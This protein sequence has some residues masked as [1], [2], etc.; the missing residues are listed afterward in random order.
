MI[1]LLTVVSLVLLI[2]GILTLWDLHQYIECERIINEI[3]RQ[4]EMEKNA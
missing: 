1:I 2:S 3:R 4:Q